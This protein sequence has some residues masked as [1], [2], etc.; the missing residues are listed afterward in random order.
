M[1]IKIDINID[2]KY[3]LYVC[4]SIYIS[5]YLYMNVLEK[6]IRGI[7]PKSWLLMLP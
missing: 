4:K 1:L 5:C 2:L 7:I 3:L 6:L